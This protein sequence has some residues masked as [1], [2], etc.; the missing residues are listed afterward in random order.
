MAENHYVD[1]AAFYTALVDYQ[2]T[3]KQ[4]LEDNKPRPKIP[5]FIGECFIKISTKFSYTRNGKVNFLNHRHQEE[6]ILDGIEACVKA[7]LSFNPIYTNPFSYF[8]QVVYYAFLRRIIKEKHQ[9]KIKSKLIAQLPFDTFDLQDH[10]DPDALN[11]VISFIVS[12][13]E[14]DNEP[15]KEKL[16]KKEK[17]KSP[18]EEFFNV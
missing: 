16:P 10:D 6:F 12:H 13:Q 4:A 15:V 11:Q 18:L 5:D 3:V 8:T 7:I 1:N 9:F 2:N 14:T 17:P